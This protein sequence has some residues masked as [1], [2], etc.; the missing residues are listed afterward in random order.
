M[1][2]SSHEHFP[3]GRI[4]EPVM[5]FRLF[6]LMGCVQISSVIFTMLVQCLFSPFVQAGKTVI[7]GM[8]KNEINGQLPPHD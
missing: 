3:L 4:P 2:F 8:I 1:H 5:G 7:F 6:K